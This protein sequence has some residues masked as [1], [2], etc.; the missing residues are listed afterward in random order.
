[1]DNFKF[2]NRLSGWIIFA[3]ALIVYVLTLEPTSSL[4]D[5]GE[6]IAAAYKL[7]VVHPPGAPSFLMLGRL[8]TMLAP[9]TDWVAWMVNFMSGLSTA[10]AVLFLFWIITHFA[11]KI[12][13]PQGSEYSHHKMIAIIGSGAIGAL[14]TTF[15][16]SV[17]FSAVEGEVYA[18]STFL[19]MLVFWSILK[20]E[21]QADEPNADRWLV[22][23]A[24][25][26]GISIGVH[27]MSLLAVPAVAL[28]YYFRRYKPTLQGG[29][30]A[31]LIG[32]GV[33]VLIYKVIVSTMTTIMSSFELF[34]VNTLGMFF[35]SG[36]IVF[37][38]LLMGLIIFGLVY[39]HKKKKTQLNI[40]ILCLLMILIGF[41]TY[42]MVIIRS[43]A[44]PAINMN[45][46]SN[47]FSLLSYLNREQYGS[48]PLLYGPHFNARPQS[49]ETTGKD[50]TKG[51]DK[52]VVK[53]EKVDYEFANE[54]M[55]FFPRMGHWQR[56][57]HAQ[58]Y[59][60]ILGLDKNEDPTFADNIRFFVEYQIG[61]MWFRYF[62]WNFSG[63][64][65]D[66]QGKK[67][68]NNDGNW[69]SGIPFID[70]WITGLPQTD[71]PDKKKNNP[72]RNTFYMLPFI[73]GLIGVFY[74]YKHHRQDFL[75]ILTLFFFTGLAEIIFLN[76]PP[77]EPRERDYSLVGSYI[78]Y[79]MW[80]GL[81]VAAIYN[82]LKER[83]APRTGAILA[84]AICLIVPGL[85][86]AQGWN[87]HDSSNRYTTRDFAK[88]YLESC[89]EDGILFTQGDNDTYP[90]W[91]IQEVEGIRTDVRVANLSLLGVD[92]YINQLRYKINDAEPLNLTLEKEDIAG[93]KRDAVRFYEQGQLSQ[94]QHYDIKQVLEFVGSDKQRTQ[95]RVSS[96]ERINYLPTKKFK[97]DVNKQQIVENDVVPDDLED[98]IVDPLKWNLGKNKNNVLKNDLI[99]L[100]I[101]GSNLWER[102]VYFAVSVSPGN[103]LG[104]SNYFQLE[105]L[106]YRV[107]PVKGGE[108]TDRTGY[109]AEDIMYKNVM[110]KFQWGNTYRDDV[111]LNENILRMTMNLRSNFG[112][113]ADKLI[114]E[115][116]KQKAEKVIDTAMKAM[117]RDQVPYNFFMLQFPDY[118]YKVD[119]QEKAR[120]IMRKLADTYK[121]QYNYYAPLGS[122]YQR[123]YQQA[124]AVIYRLQQMADR[125]G[126]DEMKQEMS[127]IM[128][129]IGA[130]MGRT[131][132]QQQQQQRAPQQQ[133]Q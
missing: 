60:T 130:G 116:K 65:N 92:W 120:E 12:I 86:G 56:G 88:N 75:I 51:E 6:Y 77:Y 128:S 94:D 14:A 107:V 96:G 54:D 61:Y 62:M 34:F 71:M 124:Q 72:G 10:F 21:S 24:L 1:M 115:G 79:T 126:D 87:D 113:L 30:I 23:I 110:N 122:Q 133:R 13:M 55:M 81:G 63:R 83:M 4:W 97:L 17:W 66:K 39:S 99:L 104:L 119:E 37:I 85:M 16:D 127:N 26:L 82:F 52:Y 38:A 95:V 76:Q 118:Y 73:L 22:F 2:I 112:R 78:S 32:T 25:I 101:V 41:S 91:Y 67:H 103:H 131:P 46:P 114:K 5:C 19:M 50:Y 18:L 98:Q 123:K 117:P 44:N 129:S 28:V 42:F 3:I 7:Q 132:Q 93:N 47:V 15:S 29:I 69:I 27:L 9:N 20:W 90:V 108:N 80:I 89:K 100:D 105:G 84:T 74:H 45:R 57:G 11:R 70:Q 53:G 58:A 59:R 31:F 43:N 33:L 106:A 48:R 68:A 125:N 49:T 8:F 40:A 111:Y 35:G 36:V 121:Q 64:Q 109:V 102:P